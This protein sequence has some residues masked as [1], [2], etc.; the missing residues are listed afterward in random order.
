MITFNNNIGSFFIFSQNLSLRSWLW[1]WVNLVFD[2][3]INFSITIFL[4]IDIFPMPFLDHLFDLNI[5]FLYSFVQ[6]T[7]VVFVLF[8]NLRD[9]S[10]DR[11]SV[12]RL[13]LAPNHLFAL[14]VDWNQS[15][16]PLFSLFLNDLLGYSGRWLVFLGSLPLEL[17][18]KRVLW[19]LNRFSELG[20]LMSQ[21]LLPLLKFLN[22]C[23]F[24]NF[25]LFFL[26]VL[27]WSLWFCLGIDLCWTLLRNF[28][29]FFWLYSW[30]FL[31]ILDLLLN[32]ISL[33][34]HFL[35]LWP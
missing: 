16:F 17:V 13:L 6:F 8:S 22:R 30:L 10:H 33:Y 7:S 1:V 3:D 28:I 34:T 14:S 21:G 19:D 9:L 35:F 18:E 11:L 24:I 29:L 2:F 23:R 5:S 32:F 15:F 4:Q 12:S 26:L 31:L 27:S 20:D 25:F